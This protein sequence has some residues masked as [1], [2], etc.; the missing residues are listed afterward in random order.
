MATSTAEGQD[1]SFADLL[2][3]HRTSAGVTQEELAD[4]AQLS[5]RGLRY[6]EQGLHLPYRDTV[7]RLAAVLELPTED[8]A[9]LAATAR[10]G[11]A[12]GASAGARP[13]ALPAPLTPLVG[14]EHQVREAVDL[15]AREDVQLVTLTG[16]GGVGKTRVALQVAADWTRRSTGTVTWV[17]L[18]ALTDPD[19]VVV[20]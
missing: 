9:A 16:P 5:V 4:R 10:T 1:P 17:P 6:L 15:L 7:R 11:S 20:A 13:T 3:H 12:R 18:E 8:T 14:R 19:L 2:R